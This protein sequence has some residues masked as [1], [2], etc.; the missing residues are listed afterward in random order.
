MAQNRNKWRAHVNTA[1]KRRVPQKCREF[2]NLRRNCW[3]VIKNSVPQSLSIPTFALW[4]VQNIMKRETGGLRAQI[5]TR[6]LIRGVNRYPESTV[7]MPSWYSSRWQGYMPCFRN[8]A[9]LVEVVSGE[10]THARTRTHTYTAR[11]SCFPSVN[12]P[13]NHRSYSTERLESKHYDDVSV[14]HYP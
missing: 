7:C 2:L 3:I 6:T 14:S 5:P 13:T 8:T 12:H 9:H 4:V 10:G 1:M 11:P